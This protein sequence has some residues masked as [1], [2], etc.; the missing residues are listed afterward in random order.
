LAIGTNSALLAHD[1]L[2]RV[3]DQREQEWRLTGA[4]LRRQR[5]GV[6]S[7]GSRQMW[8]V[9]DWLMAGEDDVFRRVKK[10]TI[11]KWA[12]E[13]TGYSQHTLV[14]AVSVARKIDPSVR[15]DGLSWWH[16]L[17]VARLQSDEQ[18]QWLCQA[19]EHGW[20]VRELRTRL[21]RSGH[22]ASR[23]PPRRG[24]L[25]IRQVVALRPGEVDDHLLA[26]LRAW[27]DEQRPDHRM[28]I[29]RGQA[30]G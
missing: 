14:M 23:R 7:S 22:M 30:D 4:R 2:F 26:Q 11:R 29:A 12:A 17:T 19:A 15:V 13:I 27:L 3:R 18:A 24:E 21:A 1:Q 16:H 6:L 5:E 8:S 25:L 28:P 9:G 20:S 10:R